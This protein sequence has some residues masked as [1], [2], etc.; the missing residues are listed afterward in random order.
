[1][2]RLSWPHQGSGTAR[3]H[4]C[5]VVATSTPSERTG[6]PPAVA[7]CP[8][9]PRDDRRRGDYTAAVHPATHGL[10]PNHDGPNHP[11]LCSHQ[12][13]VTNGLHDADGETRAAARACFA[14]LAKGWPGRA[15]AMQV[16]TLPLPSLRVFDCRLW[17]CLSLRRCSGRHCLCLRCVCSTAVCVSAFPCGDAAEDTAFAF[18]ACSTAVCG[19]EP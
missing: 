5:S 7:P 3:V 2:G 4:R 12:A 15:A 1:M 16:K 10:S 13:A 17:L 11:G 9:R 18:V 14:V 19:S 8:D 6:V